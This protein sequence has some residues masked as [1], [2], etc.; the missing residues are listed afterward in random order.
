MTAEPMDLGYLQRIGL[1]QGGA[2]PSNGREVPA[3]APSGAAKV[4]A[5]SPSVAA[6]APTAS[7]ATNGSSGGA[8]ASG[9]GASGGAK[10]PAPVSGGLTEHVFLT[11]TSLVELDGCKLIEAALA[12]KA[13]KPAEA[14]K[15]APAGAVMIT[16]ILARTVFHSQGGGQPADVGTLTAEGLPE[17]AVSF[18]SCRKTDGAILHDSWVLPATADAW[19]KAAAGSVQVSC[20]VDAV[21]RKLYARLHSAG[22]LLDCAVNAIQP[23]L[24]WVPGKGFHFPDGPYVEYVLNDDSRKIDMKKPGEKEGTLKEIQDNMDRF[25]ASGAR[26][27]I[28][29]QDGVRQVEMVGEEC[30]CGGTHVA[31]V[32]EIGKIEVRKMANKQGNIRLSY[33]VV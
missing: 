12:E 8:P 29:Y 3:S 10:A 2:A 20:H 18:V 32:S 14:P 23:P 33:Q 21:R 17:L 7:A 25:V 24:K 30:G 4:S 28:R 9:G 31:D 22:H 11:D 1:W 13:E 19:T 26:V 27:N 5:S 6:K 16:V 15:D